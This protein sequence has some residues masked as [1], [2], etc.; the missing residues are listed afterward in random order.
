MTKTLDGIRNDGEAMSA[1]GMISADSHVNEPRDLWSS[2]LPASLREQAMRGLESGEDGSWRLV[3]EGEHAF[4]KDMQSE[5]DRLAVLDPD[6]RLEVM[7][8]DGVA[9]ECIFPT[10]ALQVWMLES[11]EGGAASCRI[12]NEWIHDQLHRRSPRFCCAGLVPTWTVEMAM[13]EVTFIA[14]LG[15]GA[16]MLPAVATPMWNHRTWTPLWDQ[17]ERTGLPVVMHQGTGHDMVAYRGPGAAVANLMFIQSMA[18]RV[19]T[20]LATSGVLA[21]HPGVHVVFVEF[22]V[23]WLAWM[24][25]AMDYYNVAF[26]RYDEFR[27]FGS[28]SGNPSVYPDL[29]HP[30]SYYAKRQI[31]STFQKDDVG[32]GNLARSGAAALMWG[33]DFPHEEGTYPHSR[34]VVDQQASLIGDPAIARRVFRENALEVFKFDPAEVAPLT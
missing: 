2:N 8:T 23:G 14:E 15:L 19:G 10:I 22:N 1:I 16:V 24:M 12:Y 26:R 6:R 27:E 30:P 20:L 28:K 25:E 18:P 31:H 5:A 3:L 11:P 7:R 21:D 9:A 29:E 34:E 32:I 13:A 4:Q 33:N 17:I